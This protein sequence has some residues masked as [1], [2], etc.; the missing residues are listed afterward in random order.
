MQLTEKNKDINLCTFVKR[1]Q[2]QVD[3]NLFTDINNTAIQRPYRKFERPK[4]R[5]REIQLAS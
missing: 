2:K 1:R 3:K 5:L 4:S